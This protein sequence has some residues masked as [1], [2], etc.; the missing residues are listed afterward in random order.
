MMR[1]IAQHKSTTEPI[2][3]PAIAPIEIVLLEVAVDVEFVDCGDDTKVD[4]VDGPIV[5]RVGVFIVDDTVGNE[6][7]CPFDATVVEAANAVDATFN[8]NK[9]TDNKN[10]TKLALR[11]PFP[12]SSSEKTNNSTN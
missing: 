8:L 11:F 9:S 6:G 2:A 4:G 10:Y 1:E 12:L 7:V 3:I 5:G